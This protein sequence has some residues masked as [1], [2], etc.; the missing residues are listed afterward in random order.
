MVLTNSRSASHIDLVR[1]DQAANLTAEP[2]LDLTAKHILTSAHGEEVVR[3]I[4][5]DHQ[6]WI[7]LHLHTVTDRI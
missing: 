2:K 1:L 6:V 3:A 7:C 4:T 5:V